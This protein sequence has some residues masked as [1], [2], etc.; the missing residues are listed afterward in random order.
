MQPLVTSNDLK[1]KPANPAFG[2][3]P[4]ATSNCD[5]KYQSSL[6]INNG[7]A[8]GY[9]Y[10]TNATFADAVVY[11]RLESNLYNNKCT[12]GAN[13]LAY[14]VFSTADARFGVVCRPVGAG[15]TDPTVG[16]QSFI[17]TP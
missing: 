13:T 7:N 12:T 11:A 8:G 14:G 10:R 16:T 6:P 17:A 5:A 15:S 2:T 1:V 9:C 3:A 4:V